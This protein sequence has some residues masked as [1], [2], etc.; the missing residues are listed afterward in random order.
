M[1]CATYSI[2]FV[3]NFVPS[4]RK[5]R[6]ALFTTITLPIS[7]Y[8]F[9][10]FWAV[11]AYDRELLL[12]VR[13]ELTN[14]FPSWLNHICHTLIM[15]GNIIEMMLVKH[16]F[17]SDKKSLTTLTC[18]SGVYVCFCLFSRYE[19]GKFAYP[20]LDAMGPVGVGAVMLGSVFCILSQYKLGKYIDKL[21]GSRIQRDSD[22]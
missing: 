2:C 4:L 5:F 7:I 14:V 8:V 9:T 13:L 15:P 11:C 22:K 10:T 19:L 18:F 6:D 3:S 17:S 12:P 21:I 1:H 16:R 20:L